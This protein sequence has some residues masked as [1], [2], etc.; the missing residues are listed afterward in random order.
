MQLSLDFNSEIYP[1]HPE[2]KFTM[3]L[4]TSL[5]RLGVAGEKDEGDQ[6]VWRPDGKGRRGLEE[7]YEYVMHGKVSCPL[8]GTAICILNPH[9]KIYKFDE[10]TGENV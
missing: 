1:L 3:A 8:Q 10:G 6:A 4:A 5:S 7:D 9:L 2:E